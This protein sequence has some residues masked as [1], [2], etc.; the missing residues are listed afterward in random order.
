MGTGQILIIDDE[1]LIAEA[2]SLILADQGYE[3]VLASCGA[4]GIREAAERS[5]ELAVTDLR[6]P[7]MTGLDVLR[8][9][10]ARSPEIRVIVITAH[11][12]P[13]M[14]REL[15]ASGA[16][17]VL[18]KPFLPS[19]ILSLIQRELKDHPVTA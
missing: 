12:T 19:E 11:G 10:R 6:L 4:D 3:T 16:A 2:L 1:R 13:E 14:I 18:K 15:K 7:D 17:E 5:F 9:L 8:A